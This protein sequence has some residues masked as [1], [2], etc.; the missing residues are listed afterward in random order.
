MTKRRSV[1]DEDY[2]LIKQI[3]ENRMGYRES[4]TCH[5]RCVHSYWTHNFYSREKEC[6][7][8]CLALLNQVTI[9]ANIT[10]SQ[11]ES[12]NRQIAKK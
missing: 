4:V 3:Q 10:S 8:N 5:E 1:S 11:Y 9:I 6:M 7:E 12:H 2:E